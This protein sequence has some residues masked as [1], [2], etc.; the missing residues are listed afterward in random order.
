[1]TLSDIINSITKKQKTIDTSKLPTMGLFYPDDFTIKIK[2]ASLEDIIKYQSSYNERDIVSIIMCMK[3]IINKTADFGKYPMA[4]LKSSDLPYLFF[5]IVSFTNGTPIE[6]EYKDYNTGT[7]NKIQFT[8]DNYKYA[9]IDGRGWKYDKE[10]KAL[11]IRDYTITPPSIGL[12]TSFGMYAQNRSNDIEFISNIRNQ[13]LTFLYLV[14]NK[15]NLNKEEFDNITEI[16]F[17][18]MLQEDKEELDT[19]CNDVLTAFAYKL[20]KDKI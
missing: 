8:S 1:M 11:T 17:N 7:N 14:G 9:D 12:E 15:D 18:E 3:E 2:K 4:K 6:V 5:E 10:K 16:F 19:I 20:I 13:S